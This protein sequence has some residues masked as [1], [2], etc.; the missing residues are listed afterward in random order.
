M[1]NRDV[2]DISIVSLASRSSRESSKRV[3][4]KETL[5]VHNF[6][7]HRSRNFHTKLVNKSCPLIINKPDDVA[8]AQEPH[9]HSTADICN[10]PTEDITH[11]SKTQ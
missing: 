2:D 1:H 7:K 10:N 11:L 5:E 4:F 9:Y 6:E 8:L 3:S